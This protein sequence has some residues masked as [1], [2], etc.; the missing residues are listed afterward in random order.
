MFV[1]RQST[2]LL[3]SFNK[4][5]L[6]IS[7]VPATTRSPVYESAPGFLFPKR[8]KLAFVS[9]GEEKGIRVNRVL[10]SG[11]KAPPTDSREQRATLPPK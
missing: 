2:T 6:D 5:M 11:S 4:F 9:G 3:K 10:A 8:Q 1:A 7:P